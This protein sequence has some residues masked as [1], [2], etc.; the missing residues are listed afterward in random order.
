[1]CTKNRRLSRIQRSV[2]FSFEGGV[3][4]SSMDVSLYGL[5]SVGNCCIGMRLVTAIKKRD[6]GGEMKY[7]WEKLGTCEQKVSFAF[8]MSITQFFYYYILEGLSFLG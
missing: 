7:I 2:R 6:M 3:F 5:F 4:K 8:V 1:M